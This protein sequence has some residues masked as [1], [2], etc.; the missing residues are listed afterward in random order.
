MRDVLET[1]ANTLGALNKQVNSCL[2]NANFAAAHAFDELIH[3]EFGLEIVAEI[4]S[5]RSE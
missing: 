3:P 4:N 1:A 5:E 2:E